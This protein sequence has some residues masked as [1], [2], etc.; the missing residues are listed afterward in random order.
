MCL[1]YY[2][3]FGTVFY[4]SFLKITFWHVEFIKVNCKI[5]ENKQ[6]ILYHNLCLLCLFLIYPKRLFPHG[7]MLISYIPHRGKIITPSSSITRN[8]MTK[9]ITQPAKVVRSPKK[10]YLKYSYVFLLYSHFS[11]L[12]PAGWKRLISILHRTIIIIKTTTQVTIHEVKPR[13][14]NMNYCL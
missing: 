7:P 4:C 12:S 3:S 6:L 14:V 2:S 10:K 8:Y 1:P 13:S 5:M 9:S 11:T